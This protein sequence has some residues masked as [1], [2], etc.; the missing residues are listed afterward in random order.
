M[1][2]YKLSLCTYTQILGL[3]QHLVPH[4]AMHVLTERKIVLYLVPN[5]SETVTVRAT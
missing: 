4:V 5:L 2:V 1:H 3:L